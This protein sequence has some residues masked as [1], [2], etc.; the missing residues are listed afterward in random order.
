SVPLHKSDHD[1]R[2]HAARQSQA[3]GIAFWIPFHG[4]PV[5]RID[6]VDPYAVRSAVGTM[7]GLGYDVRSDDLDYPLLRKLALEWKD[8]AEYYF[9]DY[10]PLTSYTVDQGS[11][12][13][14]QYHRTEQNDGLIQVFRRAASPY[15]TARFKLR[16]L[17]PGAT[18][19]LTDVDRGEIARKSGEDLATSGL[20]LT[21]E[22]QPSAVTIRYRTH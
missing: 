2:D 10:Y 17:E 8:N 14:W 18:Y 15:V 6:R 9:G 7:L 16:G 11:W 5:C 4:A 3:Y 21:I 12:L 13:A 1:Y 19:V 20:I 22:E